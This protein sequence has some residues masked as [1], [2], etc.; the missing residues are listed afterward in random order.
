MMPILLISPEVARPAI[1]SAAGLV[2]GRTVIVRHIFHVAVSSVVAFLLLAGAAAAQPPAP[3]TVAPAYPASGAWPPCEIWLYWSMGSG[4]QVADRYEVVWEL[5][6][7]PSES[8]PAVTFQAAVDANALVDLPTASDP[9]KITYADGLRAGRTYAVGVRAV[10]GTTPSHSGRTENP[11]IGGSPAQQAVAFW[12]T[13]TAPGG[14]CGVE[15]ADPGPAPRLPRV[16]G[17]RARP[18]DGAA[19]VRWAPVANPHG[20]LSQYRVDVEPVS[21]GRLRRVYTASD[22]L[23]ATVDGLVNGV[24]YSVTVSALPGDGGENGPPSEPVTVTPRAEVPALP[25][26]GLLALAGLLS[27]GAAARRR[28]LGAG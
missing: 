13:N 11:E 26:A 5:N 17:V 4:G 24:E 2:R 9:Y 7:N 27:A 3:T 19:H 25:L 15:T 10:R 21:G 28:R 8:R 18:L 1:P 6:P 23:E 12:G 20:S 16:T 22:V 14:G